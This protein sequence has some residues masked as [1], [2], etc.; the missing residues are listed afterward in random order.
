MTSLPPTHYRITRWRRAQLDALA[1]A[2]R[3]AVFSLDDATRTLRDVKSGKVEATFALSY[4]EA[5]AD[6]ADITLRSTALRAA[7][8][9]DAAVN[10][11]EPE[12]MAD[13]A[14]ASLLGQPRKPG[15]EERRQHI[16]HQFV[17]NEI[18]FNNGS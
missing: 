7:H 18:R 5:A 2:L 6:A 17:N 14:A 10:D 16:A 4:F 9:M 1:Q 15:D 8:W 11:A 13:A 3:G 12:P